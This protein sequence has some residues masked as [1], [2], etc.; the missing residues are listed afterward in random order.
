MGFDVHFELCAFGPEFFGSRRS[1]RKI[2][3]RDQSRFACPA[4]PAPSLPPVERFDFE[5]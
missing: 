2:V 5:A 3:A 4:L 1:L